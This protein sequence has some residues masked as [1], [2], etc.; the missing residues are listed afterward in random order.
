[1][2]VLLYGA[3]IISWKS[4]GEEKLWLSSGAKLD[5]SKAVRGGIPLV[6]PVSAC[7]NLPVCVFPDRD[8]LMNQPATGIWQIRRP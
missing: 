4:G 8:E 5:G 7:L 6:F 3:T 1:M 2:E